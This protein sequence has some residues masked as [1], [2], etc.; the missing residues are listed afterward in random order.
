MQ[1]ISVATAQRQDARKRAAPPP[2]A[3]RAVKELGAEPGYPVTW[4]PALTKGESDMW[5]IK[6]GRLNA[7]IKLYAKLTGA[8]P[9]HLEL[10]HRD[11]QVAAVT[12][13]HDSAGC[14]LNQ[15][16][17][18]MRLAFNYKVVQPEQVRS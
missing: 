8:W 4:M 10:Y 17:K 6:F 7:A 11:G 14:D 3:V 5:P 2:V 9:R 18:N 12:F 16:I 15:P 13:D 1:N